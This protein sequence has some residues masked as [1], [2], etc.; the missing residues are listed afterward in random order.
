MSPDKEQTFLSSFNFI[1]Y[2]GLSKGVGFV[3]FDLRSQAEQAIKQLH[4]TIPKGCSEPIKVKFAGHPIARP[5]IPF[6]PPFFAAKSSFFQNPI[7]AL[8]PRYSRNHSVNT[9]V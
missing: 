7:R 4:G 6:V 8:A 3:R 9:S 5:P 1:F 2:S